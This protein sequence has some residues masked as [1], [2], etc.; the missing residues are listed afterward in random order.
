MSTLPPAELTRAPIEELIRA[1]QARPI[2]SVDELAAE[3][4]E[5]D[6]E[7]DEFLAFTYAERHADIA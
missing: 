5:S 4:F 1:K 2:R 3:T 7:L 6:E